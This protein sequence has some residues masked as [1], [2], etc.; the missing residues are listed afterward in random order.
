MK[1]MRWPQ[2]TILVLYSILLLLSAYQHG[3]SLKRKANFWASLCV[4]A[5][6]LFVLYRGGFWSH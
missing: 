4:V 3:K 6:L 2:L 1:T 5:G